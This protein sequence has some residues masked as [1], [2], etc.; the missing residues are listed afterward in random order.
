MVVTNMKTHENTC[1]H[2]VITPVITLLSGSYQGVSTFLPRSYSVKNTL[3]GR[4]IPVGIVF[5]YSFRR[6]MGG[7]NS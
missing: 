5:I 3:T 4:S 7:L 2:P 1:N 6:S